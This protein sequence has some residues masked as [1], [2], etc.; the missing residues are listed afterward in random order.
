LQLYKY[1]ANVIYII[2]NI[3]KVFKLGILITSITYAVQFYSVH[4]KSLTCTRNN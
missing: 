2:R 3:T 4:Q 1:K